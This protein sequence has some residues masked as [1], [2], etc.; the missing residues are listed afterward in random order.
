MTE[1]C[2]V[3]ID[4][5]QDT[6]AVSVHPSGRTWEVATTAVALDHLAAELRTLAPRHVVLEATGG[7]QGPVVA[8]L[9]A[10][11][12][13]VAVVNPRQVRDFARAT[14]QLAKT[15]RIDA[16]VLAQFAAVIRPP[17]RPLTDDETALFAGHVTRRRQLVEMRRE[18]E[19]RLERLR[20][21]RAAQALIRDV[22]AHVAWLTQHLDRLDGE[23]T[24][25]I[26][27]SP[28]WRVQDALYQS[29][30]AVGRVLAQTL[31]AH[32]PELG[33]VSPR[34]ISALVG[35]APFANDSGR[36]HGRRHT[37]G[38]R[39]EVRR[40]LYLA[41]MCGIRFNPVLRAHYARLLAAGKPRKVALIACA[42]KL[43]IVLNA[44]ARDQ[45]PWHTTS[46][47]YA[48]S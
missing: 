20:A 38:G 1:A 25:A 11:A 41:A 29:V 19:Q 17:V 48:A 36:R 37:R 34:V 32:L 3:G 13:P 24:H 27:A 9:A 15:D 46:L 21:R 14:G 40:V 16:A 23:L 10:V 6:V 47:T 26:A 39:V 4:V 8:A 7:L 22:E 5:G 43:L 18:E 30:P 31:I 2:V 33:R 42:H 35:V 44:I 45:Q 28:V 12:L